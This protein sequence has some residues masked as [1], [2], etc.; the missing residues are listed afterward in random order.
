MTQRSDDYIDGLQV[1]YKAIYLLF[2]KT[3]LPNWKSAY[4]NAMNEINEEIEKACAGK[5]RIIV[6]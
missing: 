3:V 2:E 4:Q 5:P 6:P 1:A